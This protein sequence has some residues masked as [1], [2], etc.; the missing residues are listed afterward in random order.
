[1]DR[2]RRAGGLQVAGT[3]READDAVGVRDIDVARVWSRRP[4]GDAER[5]VK[6]FGKGAN[7]GRAGAGRGPQDADAARPAL[8]DK[9]VAARRRPDLARI[10]EA[11]AYE[12]LD[13]K[14]GR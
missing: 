4:E 8:G 14:A 12:Q 11:A 13:G 5:L 6:V 9:D 10:I 3:V 7:L 1:N 2:L